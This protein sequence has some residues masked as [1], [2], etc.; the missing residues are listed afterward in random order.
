MRSAIAG[1]LLCTAAFIGCAG[2]CEQLANVICNCESD[3]VQQ[4]ACTTQITNDVGRI[5]FSKA[6]NDFCNEKLKTCDKNCQALRA[7]DRG[8][9]GFIKEKQR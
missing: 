4:Q 6:D 1:I 8:A 3:P 7:G 9:C 2:P 5:S